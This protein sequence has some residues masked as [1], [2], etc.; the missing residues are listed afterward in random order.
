MRASTGKY[1]SFVLSHHA[2]SL[3]V[4]RR[5]RKRH[6]RT[7]HTPVLGL[8]KQHT[9]HENHST[10]SWQARIPLSIHS[11][12]FP[13]FCPRRRPQ[14]RHLN[15]KGRAIYRIMNS[16]GWSPTA[17][18]AVFGLGITP[19]H[20]ALMNT[21]PPPDKLAKDEDY[22]WAD[23]RD[24]DFRRKF[25]PPVRRVTRIQVRV[26]ILFSPPSDNS[27]LS[28]PI[29]IDLSQSDDEED[30]K[31]GILSSALPDISS[32]AASAAARAKVPF[33]VPVLRSFYINSAQRDAKATC[34]SQKRPH[35]RES[36]R[37]SVSPHKCLC[38]PYMSGINIV[39]D[40]RETPVR[41]AARSHRQSSG[42]SFPG[43]QPYIFIPSTAH[44]HPAPQSS[45]AA[46]AAQPS[47]RRSPLYFAAKTPS[48]LP[49]VPASQ[50][51]SKLR[52][53]PSLPPH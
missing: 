31:V 24:P 30:T 45:T 22:K 10:P 14:I 37:I 15:R 11:T 50:S 35:E 39:T 27:G 5:E 9:R 28:Q 18:A 48:A 8:R 6:R 13:D 4:R 7:R 1:L 40:D 34:M 52:F 25:P 36:V 51:T 12:G 46:V 2:R 47:V 3:A 26:R 38:L 21:Y 53:N 49:H 44:R 20:R 23:K 43:I 32:P 33:V 19:I 17:I 29:V 41:P 42:E 16:H